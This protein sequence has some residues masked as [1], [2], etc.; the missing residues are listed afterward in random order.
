MLE[1]R[2]WPSPV[3]MFGVRFRRDPR[4]RTESAERTRFDR[5]A[6]AHRRSGPGITDD[7]RLEMTMT[8][9]TSSTP[10][11]QTDF[12]PSPRPARTP[13]HWLGL[14]RR[15]VVELRKFWPVIQN[16]VTQ[17][18]RVRYHRSVLGFFWTLLNPILMMTT[19]ALVFSQL[20]GSVEQG[21]SKYAIYLFAGMVPW[22]FLSGCLSECSYCIITN[23]GL[24]RKIYLPKLVFPLTRV[25]T[26][27]TTFVLS[28]GALFLLLV[29]LEARFSAALLA[30]PL[31]VALLAL[32]S[33]GLGLILATL[34]TFFRDAGHLVGVILQAW[35]F[36]TPIIYRAVFVAGGSKAPLA[37]S[38]VRVHSDVSDRHRRR[39]LARPDDDRDRR[40]KRR[41]QSGSR[42]CRVQ[43]SRR[44]A[45]FPTLSARANAPRR[46]AA[47]RAAR[48]VVAFRHLPREAIL[49][50]ARR[51]QPRVTTRRRASGH[52][53]LG[54]QRGVVAHRSR[55]TD[56]HS[57]L[58]RSGQKHP[59]P[60]P[61]AHL[62]ADA[63]RSKSKGASRL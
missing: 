30:L 10:T 35:Y 60:S 28:M 56:R 6:A 19:L 3:S 51:A 36:A 42:V 38:G 8:T 25:L 52:R 34:N 7:N 62:P 17:D 24:I 15:D 12:F 39:A 2:V 5:E 59:A 1:G 32:F 44:Q 41:G 4:T 11:R 54:D 31:A 29:P 37:Q 26:N 16:L 40:G 48:C 23:E 18:L 33:L 27:L 14:I 50:Q 58:Q 63:R 13:L 61:R 55:R 57:R 45:G 20:M 21:P 47:D 9:R 46:R 43:V 49:A 53:V 22:T